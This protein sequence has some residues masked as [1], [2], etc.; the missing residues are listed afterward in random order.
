MSNSI[1]DDPGKW[2]SLLP[3]FSSSYDPDV[4]FALY[5]INKTGIGN[6][7]QTKI[8]TL[9]FHVLRFFVMRCDY[10]TLLSSH[11]FCRFSVKI[12]RIVNCHGPSGGDRSPKLI[13][14][15]QEK[16]FSVTYFSFLRETF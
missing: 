4:G 11:S 8:F 2:P 1:L 14:K 6:E 16:N 10:V 3:S 15:D 9:V 12:N 7:R 5:D 13:I